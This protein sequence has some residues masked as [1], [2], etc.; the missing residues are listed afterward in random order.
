LDA[1]HKLAERFR[2]SGKENLIILFLSDFDPDGKEIAHSFAR[3]MRDDFGIRNLHPV[4]VALT[5][6]QVARL[7]LPP[8]LKAKTTSSNYGKFAKKHGDTAYELEAVP[9]DRLQKLTRD[10]IDAV[11]DVDA[12]NAELDAEREDA[13]ALDILR[14]KAIRSFEPSNGIDG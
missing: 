12:F 14:H 6:D 13:A 9:P 2:S 4:Q 8:T 3:S 7:Q 10:A 11:I 5:P 1:R